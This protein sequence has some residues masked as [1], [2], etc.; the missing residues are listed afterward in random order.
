[1]TSS[2]EDRRSRVVDAAREAVL[3]QGYLPV[4]IEAVASRAEV[5]KALIYARFPT[6]HDLYVAVVEAELDDLEQ[7]GLAAAAAAPDLATAATAAAEVYREH[8]ARRGPILHLIYRDPYMRGHLTARARRLRDRVL[9]GFARR[10]RDEFGLGARQAVAAVNMVLTV[11]EEAGRLVFQAAVRP[12]AAQLSCRE[13][14][15][16]CLAALR[17]RPSS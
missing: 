16:G 15:L 14:T 5:S 12:E 4:S 6:Q 11:P 7:G 8:V 10:I 13:L 3:E 1:M 2:V 9:G 17:G